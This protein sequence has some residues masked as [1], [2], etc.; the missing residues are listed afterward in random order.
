MFGGWGDTSGGG[1]F[2]IIGEFVGLGERVLTVIGGILQSSW[3]N[4]MRMEIW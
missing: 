3:L 4:T 2:L 1:R